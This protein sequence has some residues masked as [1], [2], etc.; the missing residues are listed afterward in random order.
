MIFDIYYDVSKISSKKICSKDE[1]LEA[2][3]SSSLRELITKI[4]N[5]ESEDEKRKLKPLLP[6]ISWS[7]HCPESLH[8]ANDAEP[9]GLYMIDVDYITDM[10]A[11]K[12]Y[13]NSYVD[14]EKFGIV[15]EYVTPSGKGYK[16]VA[17]FNPYR[18]MTLEENQQWLAKMCRLDFSKFW[19]V[20]TAC[21][22]WS[23][24][25]FL[26]PFEDFVYIDYSL[27]T[28]ENP[29]TKII[30]KDKGKKKVPS[31]D[32]SEGGQDFIFSK[33]V[34]EFK[35]QGKTISEIAQMYI[36]RLGEPYEGTRHMFYLS[37]AGQLRHICDNNPEVLLS[38]LPA[39]GQS[40]EDR[41]RM[42]KAVTD[43]EPNRRLPRDLYFTLVDNGLI[44]KPTW[45]KVEDDDDD[46]EFSETSYEFPTFPRIINLYA[47]IAPKDFVWPQVNTVVCI[48]GANMNIQATYLDKRV[49]TPTF[50]SVIVGPPGCGKSFLKETRELLT[51]NMRLRDAVSMER[52]RHFEEDYERTKNT[53]FPAKR[54]KLP[55]RIMI[56]VTSQVKMLKRIEDTGGAHQLIITP[57]LDTQVKNNKGALDKT[58]MDRQ[59]YDNDFYGQDFMSDNSWSGEVKLAYNKLS[60]GTEGAL[61]RMW[62]SPENGYVSRLTIS[63]C[64]NQDFVD[65]Q[66]WGEL[67]K[68]NQEDIAS[69]V[70]WCDETTYIE[71]KNYNN[72]LIDA[73]R[74]ITD[75]V[76][77]LYPVIREWLGEKL[78]L[79]KENADY[80]LDAFRKR[81]AVMAFRAGMVAVGCYKL[82]MNERREKII[83]QFV[84]WFGDR[85]LDNLMHYYGHMVT[86]GGFVTKQ[87]KSIVSDTIFSNLPNVFTTADVEEVKNRFNM[88]Q[89]PRAI[90]FMWRNRGMIKD[91]ERGKYEKVQS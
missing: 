51:T 20:D 48:L 57:E 47:K 71:P 44:K 83:S 33:G 21:K 53:K 65:F 86:R 29:N 66:E 45:E 64:T 14:R 55:R 89:P 72:D 79:A 35:F 27:F 34:K 81:C 7:C 52:Q 3:H 15:C 54:P 36:E 78:K 59:D 12:Q 11:F 60:S 67:T 18:T 24:L 80:A 23:R 4:R 25:S 76:K 37:M 62:P 39:L 70:D 68:K 56:S 41:R 50:H 5:A 73:R 13:Y 75:Q 46:V 82:Q 74:D 22:D 32:Y 88:K 43:V 8:S 49:H 69:L 90:I 31:I 19:K 26:V 58:D 30:N 9:S 17:K 38:Q 84:K 6:A 61:Y 40:F 10:D 87:R 2:I 16:I 42:C 63:E 28:D 91:I 1:F 77:F 85:A